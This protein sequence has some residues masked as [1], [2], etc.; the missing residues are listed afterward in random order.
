MGNRK[1]Q[2]NAYVRNQ[3]NGDLPAARAS[4]LGRFKSLV[5]VRYDADRRQRLQKPWS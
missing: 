2:L 5:D 4:I 3:Q 1:C